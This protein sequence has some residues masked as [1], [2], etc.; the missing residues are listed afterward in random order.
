MWQVGHITEM[1][2]T[3]FCCL[4]S[5]RLCRILHGSFAVVHHVVLTELNLRYNAL[6]FTGFLPSALFHGGRGADRN[7]S[8]AFLI[9]HTRYSD[10]T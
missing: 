1:P 6:H 10:S 4:N 2:S 7:H 5:N 9:E 8:S 3:S